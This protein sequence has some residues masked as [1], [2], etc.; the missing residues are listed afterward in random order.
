MF[1][2]YFLIS[3]KACFSLCRF[4]SF[5]F[6]DFIFYSVMIRPTLYVPAC[7]IS[8][9]LL[10]L[11]PG[12]LPAQTPATP[13]TLRANQLNSGQTSE[14]RRLFVQGVT[15]FEFGNY[16]YA[17][18]LLAEASDK[19]GEEASASLDYTLAEAFIEL[20]DGS[21]ALFYAERA[22]EKEPANKWY[23][24]KL[25]EV[26]RE[27]GRGADSITELEEAL[28]LSPGDVDL[29]YTIARVH[30][31]Q[32]GFEQA[33]EAYDRI[34][35]F[36]G[37]NLQVLYQK[38]R[39]YERMGK[40]D[41]AMQQLE[42]ILELDG[43]NEAAIQILGQMYQQQDNPAKAIEMLQRAYR[44]N[45]DNEETLI[46]LSDLYIAENRWEEATEL[47]SRMIRNPGVEPFTKVE[48]V[49][50]LFGRLRR[51]PGDTPLQQT[52]QTLLE[53]LLEEAPEFG[54]AHALAAEYYGFREDTD[55]QLK[56]LADTNTYFPDNESAWRQ[57]MQLLL[58]EDRFE[59]VLEVGAQA[60]EVIPDDAFVLFFMGNAH[61]LQNDYEAAVEVLE[62]A[63]S[64]PANRD[65]RSSVY[66]TL[67]D[68]RSSLDRWEAAK[69]AYER[70]LRMNPE[71][72]VVLNNF[73]Y[74]LSQRGEELERA[75]EMAGRALE[76]E[77]A[78]AA[79]LDTYG[80]IFY[81]LGEYDKA[82]EYI[83]ASIETGNASAT[84]YEHLGDVYD[85]RGEQEEARR[86]WQ[87]ALE[88]DPGK[89]YLNDKIQS[90]E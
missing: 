19:M 35:E 36:T 34:I 48:L 42:Q 88:K 28:R 60:D 15:E 41:L 8:A 67:G 63:S 18:E 66:G 43:T 68:A 12:L 73:A 20:E 90:A 40:Q 59:E 70:S 71:N 2:T 85:A 83:K 32:G 55:R 53:M 37:E 22:V 54:Y 65:F 30:T 72:D 38:Y 3:Q 87:E 80:W 45:P 26:Y 21:N 11:S 27:Q 89:T 1:N 5:R 58:I 50:Y 9:L 78:N 77:P 69:E 84:V 86:W 79:Y 56:H 46:T 61:L 51:S 76:V 4:F 16:E 39:N 17:A 57:R 47:L 44:L 52:T 25:A 7:L 23:R 6:A 10:T 13:D 62:R 75:R 82:E 64:A 31:L 81:K 49:Q 14:G 74:Y 24:I 29:L 33:N